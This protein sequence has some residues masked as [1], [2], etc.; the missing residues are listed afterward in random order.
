MKPTRISG[1]SQVKTMLWVTRHAD[2]E[3]PTV[4]FTQPLESRTPPAPLTELAAMRSQGA[5]PTL[6]L[7]SLPAP[8]PLKPE[9]AA[10]EP[11]YDL[12]K[13]S[14]YTFSHCRTYVLEH[15]ARKAFVSQ[16]GIDYSPGD[17]LTLW[18]TALGGGHRIYPLKQSSAR[19]AETLRALETDVKAYTKD[20]PLSFGHIVFLS[21][22]REQLIRRS[23]E[24]LQSAEDADVAFRQEQAQRDA[25]WKSELAKKD[26]EL[27]AAAD[28]LRRQ[29]DYAARLEDEKSKLREAF[30]QER[31]KLRIV[32]D[33]KDE[34]IAFLRRRYDQPQDYEGVAVWVEKHFSDRLILH[35]KAVARLNTK[36]AQCAS[37]GLICDALDFLATDYWEQRYRQLPKDIALTRCSEKYGRPFTILPTGAATIDYTPW[38]YRIPY[39]TD[40]QGH[41]MDSDLESHLR[42]G[43]EPENLLRIY[44]LH[45]DAAQRIVVG[46]LPD[47]LRAV[48]VR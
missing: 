21:D 22:A 15:A 8:L 20:K 14:Y 2:N 31:D 11:P 29:K 35:P 46:S 34:M 12:D 7:P 18:P 32:I 10:T 25:V 30:S 13:F 43:N 23:D 4:V 38:E 26:R 16:S 39:F 6:P 17:I 37:V 9:P 27:E 45:D 1:A 42:V 41:V 5:L 19:R 44:F 47:H 28:Q 48:T 3:L 33:S 36:A 40:A 24:L